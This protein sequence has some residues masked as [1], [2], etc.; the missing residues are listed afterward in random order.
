V[1]EYRQ[2]WRPDEIN[3]VLLAESHVFTDKQDYEIS[4]DSSILH[5]IIAD[6]PLRFVRFVYCL[7]Y[8]EDELLTKWRTDR[9]N[10]GTPQYWKIFSSCVAENE[11]DLGFHAILKTKTPSSIQRLRNK[12]EV[13]Q[14]MKEKGM[15]LSD[16]SIVGL[17]GSGKKNQNF[18]ETI[19]EIC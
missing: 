9:K 12:I 1:E 15:W 19:L 8:G 2:F 13:L 4:C 16:A 6:Y 14:E 17:Y 7:G 11:N 18:I 3:I 10:T 5:E